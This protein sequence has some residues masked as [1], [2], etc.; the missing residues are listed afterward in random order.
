[1]MIL[2]G[3]PT[4]ALI[5]LTTTTGMRLVQMGLAKV[6]GLIKDLPFP[7]TVEI[8]G[9]HFT[10][11]DAPTAALGDPVHLGRYGPRGDLADRQD[12]VQRPRRPPPLRCCRSR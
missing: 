5:K 4:A 8:R 11:T 3:V 6:A 7:K 1:M 12:H 9:G 10:G 2:A